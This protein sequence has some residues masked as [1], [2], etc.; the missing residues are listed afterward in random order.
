[1]IYQSLLL[2]IFTFLAA[3]I[4][5]I[6]GFGISTV[7]IPVMLLFYPLPIALL[8]VGIIHLCGDIWKMLLFKKGANLKLVLGFGIPGIILSYLGA[9]LSLNVSNQLLKKLLGVFLIIYV[10]YLFTKRKWK[11]PK[12]NITSVIGGSLSGFFAGIFGVG[13]AIRSAFLAAYNLPKENYL[14]TAGVIAF[15]I[16]VSR[17]S[18]YLT[19]GVRLDKTLGLLL[20]VLVPLS[21]L[22]AY[23][24]KKIVNKVPQKM[25]RLVIAVFLGLVGFKFLLY[26]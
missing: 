22:G 18:K 17:I 12:T 24:A 26:T 23:L 1:M 9:T 15:F 11:I 8:F 14:Y 2:A 20:I 21:L 10:I 16:D 25:F 7:M 19:G 4:G 13:G 3:L 6:S 5:T